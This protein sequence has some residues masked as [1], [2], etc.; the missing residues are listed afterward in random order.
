MSPLGFSE[1]SGCA[2]LPP[3]QE[4]SLGRLRG[5]RRH[6]VAQPACEHPHEASRRSTKRRDDVNVELNGYWHPLEGVT[7]DLS[8]GLGNGGEH[9]D[10][11]L[12]G[13]ELQ[14]GNI[15]GNHIK[16]QVLLLKYAVGGSSLYKNWRS[17]SAAKRPFGP[18]VCGTNCGSGSTN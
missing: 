17:P 5:P 18:Q 16:K 4:R 6:R 2:P 9:A 14:F 3:P 7:T 10:M 11:L 1:G 8:V 12:F 13:P 15:V